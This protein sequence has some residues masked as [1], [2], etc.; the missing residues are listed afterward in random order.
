MRYITEDQRGFTSF[1]GY[2]DYVESIKHRLSEH[3]YAFASVASR[4]DLASKGSLHDAW[5]QSLRVEIDYGRENAAAQP[6]QITVILLGPFHDRLHTLKYTDV[7]WANLDLQLLGDDRKRDVLCHELRWEDGLLQHE[8]E[9]DGGGVLE[10]HCL[11]IEYQE[12]VL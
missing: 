10:F 2:F 5:L 11:N 6:S 3:L 12:H 4:Y 9:F 1:D 7:R 8:F